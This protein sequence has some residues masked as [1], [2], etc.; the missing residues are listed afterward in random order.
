MRESRRPAFHAYDSTIKK[1][2]ERGYRIEVV[3]PSP[4][5]RFLIGVN[6]ELKT[7]GEVYGLLADLEEDS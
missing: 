7:Y 3:G 2:R 1:L 6:G 4:E 5:G